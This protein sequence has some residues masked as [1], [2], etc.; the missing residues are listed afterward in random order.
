MDVLFLALML[1]LL[2]GMWF[3]MIRPV[4]R[5]QREAAIMQQSVQVGDEIMTTAGI[6]GTVVWLDADTF[7]LQI[8]PDVTVKYA[9]AA[10]ANL[11]PAEVADGTPSDAQA[12]TE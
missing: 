4:R 8:A 11:A 6:Y 1:V 2:L 9:R 10:I 5:R 12:D 7:G 3:V